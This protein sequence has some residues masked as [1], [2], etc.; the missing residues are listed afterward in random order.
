MQ[1]IEIRSPYQVQKD[2]LYALM[3]REF[4]ARFARSRVGFFWALIEPI[5]H[6]AFPVI[7]FGFI[8]DRHVTGYDYPV[9][10]LYGL[11]PYFLFR[12]ICIQTMEGVNTS[13]GLLSYRPVHLIDVIFTKALFTLALESVL[14]LIIALALTIFYGYDLV[15]ARPIEWMTLMGGVVAFSLGLGMVFAA[16]SSFIPDT[17]AVIRVLFMPL[18]L[19]SGVVLPVARFPSQVVDVLAWNP[20]LHWVEA[21]RDLGLPDYVSMDQLSYRV[22]FF[23]GAVA[24]FVGLALYRL[25]RLSRVTT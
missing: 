17:R 18:Y 9:F 11:L 5:A 6:V 7:M 4:S 14:F 8:I 12:S 24:L 1:P 22:V 13:R 23:T 25:R 2:V 19:A 3:L 15:P 20:L 10:L 16:I 21:S